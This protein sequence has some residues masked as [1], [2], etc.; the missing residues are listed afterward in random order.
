MLK[1]VVSLSKTCLIITT[2]IVTSS[3]GDRD[4]IPPVC[5]AMQVARGR[6]GG[7]VRGAVK[8]PAG[9]DDETITVTSSYVDHIRS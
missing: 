9:R 4:V 6:G 5:R 3:Y 1:T 8:F 2:V 7:V